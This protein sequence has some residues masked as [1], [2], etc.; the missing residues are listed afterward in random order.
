MALTQTEIVLWGTA[1][2]LAALFAITLGI[3]IFDN[4]LIANESVWAK[5]LKFYLALAIHFATLALIVGALSAPYR[6]GT[7]LFVVSLV[8]AASAGFEMTYMVV[9]AAR[10]QASH[11]NL[12][13]PFHAAM[14]VLMALGAVVIVGAAGIVGII[15][16][17]DDAARLTDTLR[18]AA[19]IG[20]IGGT[21]L[22]LIVAFR[23]GAG[24]NHHIG[25]ESLGAARVPLTGW[26]RTVGDLRV[27]HFFATHMMQAVPVAGL[28][29]ERIASGAGALAL[30]WL[31]AVAWGAFTWFTFDRALAGQ[32]VVF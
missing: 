23:M 31:F 3:Q 7:L 30:V 29:I 1:A 18:T 13:T 25:T 17:L 2:L 20:L 8:A 22:T 32:S 19:A 12:S 27:P 4:R 26:S 6:T 14:Y 16:C 15:A 24:L 9:Q 10:Q 21:A 5:P 28:A 11:F